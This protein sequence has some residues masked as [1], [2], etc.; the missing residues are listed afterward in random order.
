MRL[1]GSPSESVEVIVDAA[2][3]WTRRITMTRIISWGAGVL[4]AALVVVAASARLSAQG[5]TS[6]KRAFLTFS[7]PVQVP[8]ATLPAGTYVFRIANPGFRTIWQVLDADERHVLAQFFFVRT[9]DRAIQEQNRA[10]GRPVVRFHETPRGVPPPM[11]ALYYPTDPAGH[12][13]L[14]P[15]AQAEQI[16]AM[17]HQPVLATNSNPAKSS[18]AHVMTVRPDSGAASQ[19]VDGA[20]QSR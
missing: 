6:N 19:A 3:D 8:G 4:A 5:A 1:S 14:Y 15:M 11:K 7:R 20:K 2:A 18:F 9:G 12:F 13:F 16:A 17:T 10:H